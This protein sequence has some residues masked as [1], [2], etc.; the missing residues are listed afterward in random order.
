MVALTK[1]RSTHTYIRRHTYCY[2]WDLI[3]VRVRLRV[4][5][6]IDTP[7]SR[8]MRVARNHIRAVYDLNN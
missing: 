5:L 3:D 8:E 2:I 7:R 1:I 6:A 4:S